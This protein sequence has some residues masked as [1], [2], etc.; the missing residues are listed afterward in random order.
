MYEI[1]QEFSKKTRGRLPEDICIVLRRGPAVL[2]LLI[3][4]L[5]LSIAGIIEVLH[6]AQLM[7]PLFCSITYLQPIFQIPQGL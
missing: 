2:Q 4:C 3:F 6:H 1:V 7:L 5:S